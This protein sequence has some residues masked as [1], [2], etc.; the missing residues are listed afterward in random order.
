VRQLSAGRHQLGF[1]GLLS[2]LQ[3]LGAAHASEPVLRDVSQRG[4]TAE[5]LTP[6]MSITVAH[7][8]LRRRR[9]CGAALG[10]LPAG[11]MPIRGRRCSGVPSYAGV[12]LLCYLTW[13]DGREIVASMICFITALSL[14][15]VAAV[16]IYQ[17]AA[18]LFAAAMA[19]VFLGEMVSRGKLIA[20][21]VS[22]SGVLLIASGAHD[23]TGLWGNVISALCGLSYAGTVVLARARPDVPTTEASVLAVAMVAAVSGPLAVL[24]VSPDDMALFGVFGNFQMGFALIL[25]ATGVRLIPSADAGLISVLESV[26]G[27]ALVWAVLGEK[28]GISTLVGGAVVI[29]AVIAAARTEALRPAPV[30]T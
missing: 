10:S 15:A 20:I 18:P 30:Q 4:N 29:A 25:F 26:L 12:F 22:F 19:R 5:W 2:G 1:Q 14:T 27:P 13:R 17:A 6:E 7:C 3:Q 23:A 8:W 24:T 28:P 9:L 21:L 16:L 11:S